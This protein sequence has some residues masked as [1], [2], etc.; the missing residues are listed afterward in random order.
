[1]V[2][3][4]RTTEPVLAVRQ[5]IVVKYLAPTYHRGARFRVKAEAGKRTYPYNCALSSEH[6]FAAVLVPRRSRDK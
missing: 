5:A 3:E 6:N 1:M 4:A 2:D